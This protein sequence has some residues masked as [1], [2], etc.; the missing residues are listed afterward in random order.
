M[1]F[2]SIQIFALDIANNICSI[3]DFNSLVQFAF[4]LTR[5]VYAR[6]AWVY[7][8]ITE[9]IEIQ[10]KMREPCISRNSNFA[11]IHYY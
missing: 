8:K 1:G 10:A 9:P 7:S 2:G 11:S 6:V 5:L 4:E 3:L